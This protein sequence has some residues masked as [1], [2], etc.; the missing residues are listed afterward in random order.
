VVYGWRE[1]VA[2]GG[3]MSYGSSLPDARTPVGDSFAPDQRRC[4][5]PPSVEQNCATDDEKVISNMCMA[6]GAD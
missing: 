6:L 3:L 4:R 2:A 1:H 5:A